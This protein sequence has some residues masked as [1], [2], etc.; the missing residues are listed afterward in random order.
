[1]KLWNPKLPGTS[2]KSERNPF[3]RLPEPDEGVF[4]VTMFKVPAGS[5]GV[6]AVSCVLLTNTTLVADTPPTSTVEPETKFVPF[7][8][9][10]TLPPDVPDVGVIETTVGGVTG[11]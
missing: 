9:I 5:A 3:A 1:M 7:K 8:V 10:S 6:L 11:V 4:T 2:R